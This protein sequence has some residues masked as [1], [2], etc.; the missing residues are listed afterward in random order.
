MNKHS[1][2]KGCNI[3][4]GVMNGIGWCPWCSYV[5]GRD[6]MT[7]EDAI[8]VTVLYPDPFGGVL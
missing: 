6:E 1:E 4:K 5:L 2:Y 3:Y 7:T 8:L